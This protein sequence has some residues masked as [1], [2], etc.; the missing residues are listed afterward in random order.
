[1]VLPPKREILS[2]T[3]E[4]LSVPSLKSACASR[5]EHLILSGQFKI[6]E[7][8]PPERNL[9]EQLGVSRP[10]LHEA[11]VDL[12]GKG[13]VSIIPRRGVRVSDYRNTG[14]VA[15]LAALLSYSNGKLDA[16]F[17][18]SLID[19]RLLMEVETAR[20][21]AFQRTPGHLIEFGRI[22][23]QETMIDCRNAATLAELDFSFHLL[24]ANASGNLMYPLIMNSF[25]PVYTNLTQRF[26]SANLGNDVLDEVFSFHR[27]LVGAIDQRDSYSAAAVMGELLRHGAAHL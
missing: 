16:P 13:L 7:A 3:V 27:C 9:A 11:L 21:A 26:F 4:P 1:V 18:Q 2:I 6:G 19:M 5:L 8:L 12:A 15:L 14:S 10:V 23:E 24:V 20:L 25:K 22:L 17:Q